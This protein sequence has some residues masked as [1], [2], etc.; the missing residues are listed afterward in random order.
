M[1]VPI[2]DD[3]DGSEVCIKVIWPNSQQY[4]GILNGL[5]TQ[6]T[7]GRFWDEKTGSIKD[8]QAIAWYFF[9]KNY[10]FRLCDGGIITD[11]TGNWFPCYSLSD[12][13]DCEDNDMGCVLPPGVIRVNSETG[14]LQYLTCEGWRDVESWS[15][16]VITNPPPTDNEVDPVEGY[17]CNKSYGMAVLFATIVGEVVV[18]L[19]SSAAVYTQR[20]NVW[21]VIRS[22]D[23]IFGLAASIVEQW[24][25]DSA[26][27]TAVA[28]SNFVAWLACIWS[29]ATE[30][31]GDLTQDEYNRMVSMLATQYTLN[32]RNFIATI[33]AAIGLSRFKWWAQSSYDD[34]ATCTCPGDTSGES[35]V[36]TDGWYLGVEMVSEDANVPIGEPISTTWGYSYILNSPTHDVYG[37]WFKIEYVSGGA[38]ASVKRSNDPAPGVTYDVYVNNAN[39]DS[40]TIG[41]TYIQCGTSILQQMVE[42]GALTPYHTCLSNSGGD[43]STNIAA[44][45]ATGG[46]SVLETIAC[47]V[48]GS[49]GIARI[50]VRW[51][52][53][54]NSPSHS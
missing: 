14:V 52:H 4:I 43:F 5:L 30:N 39:S 33:M 34:T 47:S 17:S 31:T 10:P 25:A 8:A 44:P 41:T 50:R 36:S 26:I 48:G 29:G 28:D 42:S 1:K 11:D 46:Q 19:N 32:Q 21:N 35:P 22:Y 54:V 20:Q 13:E 9:E 53:N 27:E 45:I 2:P 38:F 3:W 16:T 51:L 18:A 37:V 7:R 12:Y 49:A 6:L 15:G 23:A 40:L 24:N